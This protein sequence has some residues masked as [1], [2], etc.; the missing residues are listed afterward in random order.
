MDAGGAWNQATRASDLVARF[1][2]DEFAL[3]M[4]DCPL[5][6]AKEVVDRVRDSTPH[7]QMCSAGLVCW[8]GTERAEALIGR[9]DIN[10][11]EAKN[12]RSQTDTVKPSPKPLGRR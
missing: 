2:G 7:G 1:G 3:I 6:E 10:L 5:A 8:D 12:A 4:S 11:Y 9:A